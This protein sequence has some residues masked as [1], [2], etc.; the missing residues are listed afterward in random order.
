MLGAQQMV[1]AG[2]SLQGAAGA[3]H[4]SETSPLQRNDDETSDSKPPSPA[5]QHCMPLSKH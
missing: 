2:G 5:S 4:G 3:G 1:G